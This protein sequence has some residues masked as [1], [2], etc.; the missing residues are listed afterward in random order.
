MMREV[1]KNCLKSDLKSILKHQ[2]GTDKIGAW[3]RQAKK[4]IIML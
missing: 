3:K 4:G 2:N 1:S